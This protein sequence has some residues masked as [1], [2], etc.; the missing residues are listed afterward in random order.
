MTITNKGEVDAVQL[1]VEILFHKY[2]PE[3]DRVSGSAWHV[4]PEWDQTIPDTLHPQKN[5]ST[6]I[7][8]VI[9]DRARSITRKRKSNHG[10]PSDLP[11]RSLSENI[12]KSAFYYYN[13]DGK[14][15]GERDNSLDPKIY[16]PV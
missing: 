5:F 14:L 7:P 2:D 10:N 13:Q 16:E 4:W 11:E 12:L 6:V 1:R 3:K 15:V 9:F 8:Q